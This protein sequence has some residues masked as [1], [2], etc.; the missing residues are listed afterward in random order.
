M[1]RGLPVFARALRESWRGVA[2]WT[3]GLAAVLFLYL[4]LYPSIGGN[5]EMQAIIDSLP[6][7]LVS[8][9]GYDQIGSGAGYTQATFFGLMGFLLLTIAAASWGSGAIAG[10]EESGRLELDLAHAIGRASY[11][12]QA[13]LAL[14]AR[15]AWLVAFAG[16]VIA[17]L[18]GS[19]QLGL[20]GWKLSGACLA[21]LGQ[22]L[23][24]GTAGLFAGALTGRRVWALAAAAGIAVIGYALNAV[25]NQVAALEW[26]HLLSPYAWAF[27]QPPLVEG[28]SIVGVGGLWG[29]SALFIAGAVVALQRRDLRG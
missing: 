21:L 11:A 13:A 20:D 5:G 23:L 19:A 22:A 1:S 6:A 24:S 17:A 18:N 16:I 3:A 7:E 4:P 25:A 2:L 28:V 14:I 9:L 12:G 26:L 8:S 15:L 27:H 10:A 29:V